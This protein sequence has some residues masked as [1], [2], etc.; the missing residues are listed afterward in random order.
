[1]KRGYYVI[2]GGAAVFVA[3]ISLVVAWALPFASRIQEEASLLR[4]ASLEP[5][6]SQTVSLQ[7]VDAAKSL[8]IVVSASNDEQVNAVLIDPAGVQGINSTFTGTNAMSAEP[9][10]PGTYRLVVTNQGD[11]PTKVDVVFGH[12]PGIGTGVDEGMFAGVIA[13]SAMAV[14]GV[15]AMVAGAV[16]V[17][18]QGRR[19]E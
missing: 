1:V 12:I 9:T 18:V 6:Q 10:V 19:K 8:S 2:I 13:G 3:G 15:I 4:D 7:V 16:I 14:A 17:A 11:R 5:G